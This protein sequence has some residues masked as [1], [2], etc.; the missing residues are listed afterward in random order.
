MINAT[1]RWVRGMRLAGLVMLVLPMAG[2]LQVQQIRVETLDFND[3][4]RRDRAAL[5]AAQREMSVDALRFGP[6]RTSTSAITPML[7]PD[8]PLAAALPQSDCWAMA[9]SDVAGRDAVLANWEVVGRVQLVDGSGKRIDDWIDPDDGVLDFGLC[10]M[11]DPVTRRPPVSRTGDR[12]TFLAFDCS[13]LSDVGIISGPGFYQTAELDRCTDDARI[14]A[15]RL[16]AQRAA[17]RDAFGRCAAERAAVG[18][19][20]QRIGANVDFW[21]D[22]VAHPEGAPSDVRLSA[23]VRD[24]PLIPPTVTR[25]VVDAGALAGSPAGAAPV[26]SMEPVVQPYDVGARVTR[27]LLADG[28]VAAWRTPMQEHTGTVQGGVRWEE[29]WSSSLLVSE[30]RIVRPL[31]SVPAQ[32]QASIAVRDVAPSRPLPLCIEDADSPLAPASIACRFVCEDSDPLDGRMHYVLDDRS[33]RDFQGRTATP[34]VTPTYALDSAQ[35]VLTAGTSLR[36]PL[37]W[38]LADPAQAGAWIEFGLALRGGSAALRSE[39]TLV[40]A[41]SLRVGESRRVSFY[42]DNVGVHSLR[43][44][45]VDLLPSSIHPQDF[46]IE[47]PQDPLPVPIGLTVDAGAYGPVGLRGDGY[48]DPSLWLRSNEGASHLRIRGRRELSLQWGGVSL[49]R[50]AGLTWR[51]VASFPPG[52]VEALQP[53]SENA[54]SVQSWRARSL[55]TVLRA[56][57]GFLVS[58][59]A[60]PQAVGERSA[61]LRVLA[62]VLPGGATVEIAVPLRARGL[63]GPMPLFQPQQL[64]LVAPGAE[65]R[66]A[67]NV[68]LSNDGDVATTLSAPVLTGRGGASLGALAARLRVLTPEGASGSIASGASRLARVEFIG[69]CAG[70][71]ALQTIEAE[72][73]WATPNS[74]SIL[75]IQAQ[76]RCPP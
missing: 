68:L 45:Q 72:L 5:D 23:C 38:T 19:A 27:P 70:T 62:D 58:V 8:D 13:V 31:A 57:E 36:R 66:V 20:L 54:V 33:C 30:V 2:C 42:V 75:P 34:L 46:R 11:D 6:W 28:P 32:A 43:V 35:A 22:G 1:Q 52:W 69:T 71:G 17:T 51:D 59:L 55:P 49:R 37:R 7:R 3:R 25:Y 63:A 18:G 76:T 10:R 39:L 14:H 47:L 26:R 15:A 74:L 44:R 60:S 65:Q 53:A 50:S 67:R 9:N 56:R 24:A 4:L 12:E 21:R 29:G 41:G 61:R 73:R 48:A 40:D 16:Y 64:L